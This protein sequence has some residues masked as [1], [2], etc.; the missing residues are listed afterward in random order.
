MN[1]Q[2]PTIST[3][4]RSNNFIQSYPNPGSCNIQ[5]ANFELSTGK[6]LPLRPET[7]PSVIVFLDHHVV[8][9]GYGQDIIE[10]IFLQNKNTL[11]LF[12]CFSVWIRLLLEPSM[13]LEETIGVL[14]Y[15]MPLYEFLLSLM[16][17]QLTCEATDQA[18]A[19]RR[20]IL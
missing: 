18:R 10:L 11:I 9:E 16:S 8:C 15:Q 7:D 6:L 12:Q 4:S 13:K 20:Q 3:F 19:F 1:D 5:L 2:S 17:S 14:L